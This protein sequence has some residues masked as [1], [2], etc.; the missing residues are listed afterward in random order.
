MVY[1]SPTLLL[2]TVLRELESTDLFE[3]S[4]WQI[5]KYKTGND[6]EDGSADVVGTKQPEVDLIQNHPD[7]T[8]NQ[9]DTN[10]NAEVSGKVLK[11]VVTM[12]HTKS[13][14]L[15]GRL[16]AYVLKCIGNDQL[17]TSILA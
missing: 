7:S 1:H 3:I 13:N 10:N 14:N 11:G 5:E 4:V 9:N 12:F 8:P 15:L 16:S 6:A 2:G 17:C